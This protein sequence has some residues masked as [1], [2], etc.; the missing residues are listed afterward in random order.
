M[1]EGLAFVRRLEQEEQARGRPRL[2]APAGSLSHRACAELGGAGRGAATKK[3]V[4]CKLPAQHQKAGH[5]VV[6]G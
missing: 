3:G 5:R 6:R 4:I 1:P 2:S